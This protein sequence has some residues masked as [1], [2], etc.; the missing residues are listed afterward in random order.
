LAL[1][2]AV[3]AI[4]LFAVLGVAVDMGRMFIIKHEAQVFTD[5]AALGAA[6]K[7]DG[8]QAGATVGANFV[9]ASPNRWNAG[10]QAFRRE[11]GGVRLGPRALFPPRP[12]G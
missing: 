8:T 4:V 10:T 7:L 11:G 5:A 2:S 6:L 1:G 9:D 12:H 3:M